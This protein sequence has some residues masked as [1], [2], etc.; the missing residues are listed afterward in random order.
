MSEEMWLFVT[1]NT[2]I[3]LR[4]L[5]SSFFHSLSQADLIQNLL[6]SVKSALL[7]LK[8]YNYKDFS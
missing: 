2:G 4:I 6:F 8:S 5:T 1:E 7:M 3:F